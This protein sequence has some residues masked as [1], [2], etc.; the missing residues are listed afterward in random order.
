MN[1]EEPEVTVD[2]MLAIALAQAAGLDPADLQEQI[3]RREAADDDPEKLREKIA[4]LEQE[5]AGGVGTTTTP[6]PIEEPQ[7]ALA[8]VSSE[9]QLAEG[10]R[11]GINAAMT[12][13]FS[14][15]GDG[16]K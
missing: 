4:E 7:P 10:L 3:R 2:P 5:L 13:W 12:P 15:G 14:L 8:P 9:Q 6:T 16:A 1:Q 11:D